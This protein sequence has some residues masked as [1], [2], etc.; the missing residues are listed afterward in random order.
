MRV[1]RGETSSRHS[2]QRSAK[3]NVS[4]HEA[5]PDGRYISKC[6]FFYNQPAFYPVQSSKT[7]IAPVKSTLVTG[8]WSA[9]LTTAVTLCKCLWIVINLTIFSYTFPSDFV[10]APGKSV[11]IWARNQG[12]LSPPDQLIF[13]DEDSFGVGNNVQTILYNTQGEVKTSNFTLQCIIFYEN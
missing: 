2:Y 11:K 1:I 3:G 9:A 4:I 8:S 13:N 5:S 6:R 7:L 10:L 12:V